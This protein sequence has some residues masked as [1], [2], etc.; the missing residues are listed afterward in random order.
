MTS[1]QRVQKA[2]KQTQPDRPPIDL[3]GMN[4]TGIAG[5]F[6]SQY[7]RKGMAFPGHGAISHGFGLREQHGR[8]PT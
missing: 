2:M 3:G 7:F 1:R 4:T 8:A 5:D 6:Y